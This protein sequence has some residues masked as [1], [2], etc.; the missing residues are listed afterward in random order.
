MFIWALGRQGMHS[1]YALA[2]P[3]PNC[4]EISLMNRRNTQNISF[5][6]NDASSHTDEGL[7]KRF[8]SQAITV[9]PCVGTL[10][11][12]APIQ[13]SSSDEGSHQINSLTYEQD[14]GHMVKALWSLYKNVYIYIVQFI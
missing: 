1:I 4:Q 10:N 7:F 13:T 8:E 3:S 5:V 9:S 12:V 14:Q 2:S 11:G 6:H